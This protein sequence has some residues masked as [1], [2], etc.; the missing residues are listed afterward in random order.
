MM[1][2]GEPWGAPINESCQQAYTPVGIACVQCSKNIKAG[3]RGLLIPIVS[4]SPIAGPVVVLSGDPLAPYHLACFLL[5]CVPD[6]E[7]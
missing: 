1:Y 7:S 2:F 5:S 4:S 3:D 6:Y